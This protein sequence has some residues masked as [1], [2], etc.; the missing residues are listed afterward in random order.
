MRND[1]V[2]IGTLVTVIVL[3]GGMT[4]SDARLETHSAQRRAIMDLRVSRIDRRTASKDAGKFLHSNVKDA[5]RGL[6]LLYYQ[7]TKSY[8]SELCPE[9]SVHCS[10]RR[11]QQAKCQS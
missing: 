1:V 4:A 11:H 5:C 9:R 8:R 3:I 2:M 6:T 10:P 7:S